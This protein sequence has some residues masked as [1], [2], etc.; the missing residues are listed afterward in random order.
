MLVIIQLFGFKFYIL[1]YIK[2][3]LRNHKVLSLQSTCLH[4]R[5]QALSESLGSSAHVLNATLWLDDNQDV[6]RALQM[7]VSV[8]GQRRARDVS[9]SVEQVAS[10]W[11]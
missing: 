3:S 7:C 2:A 6:A 1:H 8:K 5:K 4:W 11:S 9:C 10:G